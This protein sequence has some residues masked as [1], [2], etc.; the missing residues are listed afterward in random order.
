MSIK[1]IIGLGNPG[2]AYE[3]TRHNVGAWYAKSLACQFGLNLKKNAQLHADI[4]KLPNGV[5][6]VIPTTFMNLSGQS[7]QAVARFYKIKPEEILIAHDELDLPVGVTKLKYDGGHGGHNG[8][9]DTIN[10]LQNKQFWRL[11]IGIG[12]PG[13]KDLVHNYVLG[14]PSKDDKISIVCAIDKALNLSN[15]IFEGDMQKAMHLLHS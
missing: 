13:H 12:H 2:S 9:R 5:W 7:V 1:L 8:L 4:A 6:V 10:K 3:N 11:R 15:E 14:K